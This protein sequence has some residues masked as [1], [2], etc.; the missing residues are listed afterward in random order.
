MVD[1]GDTIP[2]FLHAREPEGK[3][4]LPTKRARPFE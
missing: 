4:F 2:E 3:E 1:S